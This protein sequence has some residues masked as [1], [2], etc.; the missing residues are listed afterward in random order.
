M[1]SLLYSRIKSLFLFPTRTL[2]HDRP[3]AQL[4]LAAA[5]PTGSPG[6]LWR[7]PSRPIA[8]QPPS[9]PIRRAAAGPPAPAAA[10]AVARPTAHAATCA[11][12]S[13][14]R[15]HCRSLS[16]PAAAPAAARTVPGS[17]CR[18]ARALPLPPRVL[19]RCRLP[20]ALSLPSRALSRCRL[21]RALSLPP[22]ARS[23]AAA[24]AHA[25]AATRTTTLPPPNR[26]RLHLEHLSSGSPRPGRCNQSS[27]KGSEADWE[28]ELEKGN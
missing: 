6:Y 23:P 28:R 9:R 10:H 12:A 13:L 15:S 14:T 27:I 11:L 1:L 16:A 7:T 25:P 5:R 17:R 2:A 22:R 3:I 4:P 8:L 18:L 21:A 19:S 26:P 24:H 20:R